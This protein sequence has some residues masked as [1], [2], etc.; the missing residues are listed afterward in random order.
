MVS[1]LAEVV[2]NL[3]SRKIKARK[4]I[5]LGGDGTEARKTRDEKELVYC[6]IVC[7]GDFGVAT[8]IFILTCQS[9]KD[10]GGVNADGIFAA[11]KSACLEYM[12]Q[13][14]LKFVL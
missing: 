1:C 5:S 6:K 9:A 2:T 11:M 4:F 10:F 13:E 12:N 7:D 3:V 14:E 8:P